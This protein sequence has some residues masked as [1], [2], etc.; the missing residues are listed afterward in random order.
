M[1]STPLLISYELRC[2]KTGFLP[3][4]KTKAQ[5]SFAVPAKLISAFVFYTDGTISLLLKSKI[6]S[7]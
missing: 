7:F 5:I 4:Q 2:E 6:S 1:Q 3:L